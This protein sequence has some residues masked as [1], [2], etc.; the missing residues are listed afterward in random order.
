MGG[1]LPLKLSVVLVVGERWSPMEGDN[2][3]VES[4]EWSQKPWPLGIIW[5]G[6]AIAEGGI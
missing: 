5:G 3:N 6:M 4:E 2:G 1:V